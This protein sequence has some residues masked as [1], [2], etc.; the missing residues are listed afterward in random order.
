MTKPRV[1]IHLEPTPYDHQTDY[2]VVKVINSVE[3][4]IGQGLFKHKVQEI[5]ASQAARVVITPRR[6][7]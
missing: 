6:N 2:E 1:E 3:F 7:R 5:I 4:E